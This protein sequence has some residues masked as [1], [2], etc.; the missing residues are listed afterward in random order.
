[1]RGVLR[2]IAL[3]T[4]ILVIVP[5]LIVS[6]WGWLTPPPSS[7]DSPFDIALYI[8][9]T[10]QVVMM[11]LE[12]Y[13]VGVV[14]AEMPALFAPAAL[15]AQAA[16]A[17]SY[18]VRRVRQFGGSGCSKHSLADVCDDPAHCQAYLPVEAMQLK[19]GMVAFSD[20]YTRIRRAVEATAGLVITYRGQV[21]DPIFH[22]TC[23]GKTEDANKV[24]SNFFPYLVSVECGYCSHSVRYS[25]S[26]GFTHADLVAALK[27]YD[28]AVTVTAQALS[29]KTPPLDIRSRS[30]TGRVLEVNV[31][32]KV[33]KGTELRSAL[34]LNST[35]FTVEIS[36]TE[37]VFTTIGYGH[38]V[39]LCQ[40]GADG[41]A[42]AGYDFRSILQ[43]YYQGA[44]ITALSSR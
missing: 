8:T 24:W 34:G 26:K 39:G 15:E 42:K 14:A 21:I 27:K 25:E 4:I 16:A 44:S 33:L 32:G 10:A 40:Y 13:V 35:N 37:A 38:G 18:A 3:I 22:S 12:E 30:E 1:M 7:L 31:G 19:W 9:S 29:G 2:Y 23:G 6:I 36:S 5:A 17:R 28:A 41:M 11:P 20:N 43:H